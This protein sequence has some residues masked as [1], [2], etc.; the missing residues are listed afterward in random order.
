MFY[1]LLPCVVV[2]YWAWQWDF[3][4]N[5]W[6]DEQSIGASPCIIPT[7][8]YNPL[9][10]RRY[11]KNRMYVAKYTEDPRLQTG[12]SF[13]PEMTSEERRASL[14]LCG[15]HVMDFI[16]P[17]A[18]SMASVFGETKNEIQQKIYIYIYKWEKDDTE[19]RTYRRNY[20][21]YWCWWGYNI[22]IGMT[23]KEIQM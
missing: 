16:V 12:Y 15:P 14:N 21:C 13:V 19:R 10:K 5:E 2:W 18:S 22:Y 1:S 17:L 23:Q 3:S 11:W 7:T 9:K 6:F 20:R 8:T 4:C